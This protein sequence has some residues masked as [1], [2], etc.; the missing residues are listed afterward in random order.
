MERRY[1]ITEKENTE[2]VRGF[3]SKNGQ[4][5]LPLV[6]QIEQ[7]EVAQDEL[8]DPDASGRHGGNGAALIG[9]EDCRP[10]ASGKERRGGGVA[11]ARER[12]GVSEGAEAPC[13]ATAVAEEGPGRRRLGPDASGRG[14]HSG[15]RGD[16]LGREVGQPDAGDP[17]ARREKQSRNPRS[18]A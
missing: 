15:L 6:E 13:E 2:A 12:H 1:H 17:V 8:I 5:L 10:T 7:A 16:A 3:L 9:G 4:A 11:R 18:R 14:S